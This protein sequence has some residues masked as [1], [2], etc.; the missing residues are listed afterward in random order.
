MRYVLCTTTGT[1]TATDTLRPSISYAGLGGVPQ[2]RYFG[3]EGVCLVACRN[4]PD[5]L[6]GT[7]GV[8]VVPQDLD[9]DIGAQATEFNALLDAANLPHADI[10]PTHNWRPVLKKL[11][12]TMKMWEWVGERLQGRRLQ[13]VNLDDNVLTLPQVVRDRA[14]EAATYLGVTLTAGMTIRQAL[15]ALRDAVPV[16]LARFDLLEIS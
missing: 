14:Q 12:Q 9:T 8:V 2:I 3:M 1:R 7:P 6:V 16:G 13:G 5:F 11:V 15:V 4:S 10:L